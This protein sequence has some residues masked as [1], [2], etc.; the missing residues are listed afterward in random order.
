MSNKHTTT[1]KQIERLWTQLDPDERMQFLDWTKDLCATCG[2]K[3]AW[4]GM[5]V[6]NGMWCD[7]C[8]SERFLYKEE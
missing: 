2:C 3:G 8:C 7:D 1:L 6:G 4:E 5:K